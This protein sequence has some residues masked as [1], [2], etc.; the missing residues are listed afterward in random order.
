MKKIDR[1]ADIEADLT[2]VLN[3]VADA[4]R[5]AYWDDRN[6]ARVRTFKDL[7]LQHG[8]DVQQNKCAWCTLPI[9]PG[10]RRSC[11]RDHVAPKGKYSRWTFSPENLVVV[12]ESC[13]G[14]QIKG[15]KDTVHVEAYDYE[16]TTFHIVH[17]YR[18]D[19][20][21]HLEFVQEGWTAV[22]VRSKTDKGQWTIT[23]MKLDSPELTF[24]R[25]KE[26]VLAVIVTLPPRERELLEAALRGL[27]VRDS[28][29]PLDL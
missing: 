28:G 6:D 1:C 25:A 18:D 16:E 29:Q 15:R 23:N 21:E 11:E 8:L 20:E 7:I 13:N 3:S 10:A 27:T 19:P 17:P 24:E 5:S 26:A 4:D 14:P 9:G 12:C 22:L 2:N